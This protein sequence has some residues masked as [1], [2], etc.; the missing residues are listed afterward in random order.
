M[1]YNHEGILQLNPGRCYSL[2]LL[3]L[4]RV[5]VHAFARWEIA[6]YYNNISSMCAAIAL[7]LKYFNSSEKI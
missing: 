2:E 4:S 5:V 7:L 3:R 1:Y 6:Y